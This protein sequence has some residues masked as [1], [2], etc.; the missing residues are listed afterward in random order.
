[1]GNVVDG[2]YY[3]PANDLIQLEG[4]YSVIG[5]SVIVHA[6]ADNCLTTGDTSA[7]S[8]IGQCVIGWSTN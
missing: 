1:M 7:G 5:R 2:S 3:D 4:A 6:L 8:R